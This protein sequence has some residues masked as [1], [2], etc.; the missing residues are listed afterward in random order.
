[1]NTEKS[2]VSAIYKSHIV[3]Q[4]YMSYYVAVGALAFSRSPYLQDCML[5]KHH[6]FYVI[7][8][9]QNGHLHSLM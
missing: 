3:L 6:N 9:F 5:D 1:M 8:E 2:L 7:G 4:V